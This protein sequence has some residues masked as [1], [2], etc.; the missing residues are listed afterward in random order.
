MY[1]NPENVYGILSVNKFNPLN[2][3][4]RFIILISLVFGTF[5]L[6][7]I[8][9]KK[10]MNTFNEIIFF[11]KKKKTIENYKYLNVV[12]LV[13][14]TFV[15]FE[16]LSMSYPLNEIDFFHEGERLSPAKNY[17]LNGKIWS[18]SLFIHGA[19]IDLFEPIIG[20]KPLF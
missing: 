14:L 17:L 20:W 2:N 12:F 15:T 9:Y 11:E 18:G 13:F 8:F 1:E 3:D 19:F 4:L 7:L 10:N 6:S 5:F 16:F